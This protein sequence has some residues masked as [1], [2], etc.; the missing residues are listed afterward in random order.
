[1]V[2]GLGQPGASRKADHTTGKGRKDAIYSSKNNWHLQVLGENVQCEFK[3]IT[4]KLCSSSDIGKMDIP[5]R[6]AVGIL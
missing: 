4:Y 2:R 6:A 1:M 5:H 3:Q